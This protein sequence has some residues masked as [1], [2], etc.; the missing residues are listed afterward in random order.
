ML[1]LPARFDYASCPRIAS[2]TNGRGAVVLHCHFP[3]PNGNR[4]I[5]ESVLDA[6]PFRS[7]HLRASRLHMLCVGARKTAEES[8]CVVPST[9]HIAPA[10]IA[11]DPEAAAPSACGSLPAVR[12]DGEAAIRS[13]K[14]G[15]AQRPVAM[16]Q[17]LG[18]G[19]CVVCELAAA[20]ASIGVLATRGGADG[21][22]RTGA[23]LRCDVAGGVAALA[24]TLVVVATICLDVATAPRGRL[25]MRQLPWSWWRQLAHVYLQ[26]NAVVLV[27]LALLEHST[28]VLLQVFTVFASACWTLACCSTAA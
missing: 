20:L 1:M 27:A 22:E 14:G 26:A 6:N 7:R 28:L 25:G 19:A 17:I 11:H 10:S 16:R 2:R 3:G 5:V 12:G 23:P 8:R 21:L 24:S 13:Q 9:E 15:Q 4:W 18:Y